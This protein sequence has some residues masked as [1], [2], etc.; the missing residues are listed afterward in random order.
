MP[1]PRRPVTLGELR[2]PFPRQSFIRMIREHLALE[3]R[4]SDGEILTNGEEKKGF[5]FL[6]QHSELWRDRIELQCERHRVGW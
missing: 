1:G 2:H 5:L 4:L 6:F 3:P